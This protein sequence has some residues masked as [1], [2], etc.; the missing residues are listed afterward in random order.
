MKNK[1]YRTDCGNVPRIVD[2]LRNRGGIHVWT[3]QD[4]GDP[5]VGSQVAVPRQAPDGTVVTTAPHW[6]YGT[7]FQVITDPAE[8]EVSVIVEL[9]STPVAFGI[10]GRP[11]PASGRRLAD[12]VAHYRAKYPGK[13]VWFNASENP[14]QILYE[15]QVVSL[16]EYLAA[17]EA[18]KTAT[19]STT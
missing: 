7:G 18:C 14:A 1:P 8:V 10:Q 12:R 11:T 4:L 9:E 16:P 2:W 5:R 15:S 3:N 17:E 19:E 13:D 6:K